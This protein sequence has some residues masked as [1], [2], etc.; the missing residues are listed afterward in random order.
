M[1]KQV[2]ILMIIVIVASNP[3]KLIDIAKEKLINVKTR[4]TSII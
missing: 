3:D 1:A 4:A 2:D